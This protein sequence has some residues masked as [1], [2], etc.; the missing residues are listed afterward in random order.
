[1][2]VAQRVGGTFDLMTMVRQCGAA[3]RMP[4]APF[5]KVIEREPEAVRRVL[6]A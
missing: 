6:A 3:R 4:R 1:M 5:L 2:P